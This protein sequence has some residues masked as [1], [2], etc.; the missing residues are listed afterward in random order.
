MKPRVKRIVLNAFKIFFAVG[1]ITWLIRSGRLDLT[2]FSVILTPWYTLL[3]LSLMF[4]C[5]AVNNERW[6][7]LLHGQG[8]DVTFASTFK[9]SLMGLFFNFAMPGGVG[10]DVIKA[11]YVI[12]D[13]PERRMAAGLSVLMDRVVGLYTMMMLAVGV[14]ALDFEQVWSVFNLRMLF[15]LFATL[16]TVATICFIVAFSTRSDVRR[17]IQVVTAKLPAGKRI[18]DIYEAIHSYGHQK[19][20]LTIAVLLSFVSQ[21]AAI[22]LSIVVGYAMGMTEV[23]W[24]AYFFAVPVSAMVIAIPISPAGIGLGQAASYI[25]FNT[26]LGMQSQLGPTTTTVNQ[27]LQFAFG[28]VGVLFYLRRKKMNP[29]IA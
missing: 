28:L 10:G 6:R 3:C 1:L 22:F 20:V 2:V 9:L 17:F 13:H 24:T 21:T 4:I 23:P 11:Y 19:K 12:Q 5:L 26:Y 25:L 8:C 15:L 16:F 27:V 29:V 7:Q 18:Y 14:M